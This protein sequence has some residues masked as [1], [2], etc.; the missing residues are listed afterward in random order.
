MPSH[1]TWTDHFPGNFMWSN[2]TLVCKGMAP[3]GAV[4]LGEIELICERLH[5]REGEPAA[6]GEEW[7]ALAARVE[8][9]ADQAAAQG[10][11][12]T[13]GNCYLRAG[14]YY[15]TGERFVP[16]GEKKLEIYRKALRCSQEGLKR[17][18]PNIEFVEVPYEGK[19]LPAYFMKA[20]GANG[21][22][23]KRAP[24]V[25]LFDGMDNCKEM[26]VLFAGIEFAHRGIHTL[27]IDGP[28]QGE[29]LRLRNIYARPDYEVAGTAAYEFV[30][31]RPDVDAKKV[32]I[33]GYSFGGYYAPR[34]AA[35]EQRYAA[36]VALGALHWDLHAWQSKIKEQLKA[37]PKKSAQSNFQFQWIL[38]VNDSEVALER[39]RTFSLEGIANRITCPF[40]V[41]HGEND[42]VVPVAAAHKLHA[43]VGSKN[44]T[45]KIF[46]PEE[47]G[48]EHCQVDNRQLGIDYIADW[49]SA[50][51]GG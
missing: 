18:H 24:T 22:S 38:G 16:L 21:K 4:A 31:A 19:T 50:N 33:M 28:G 41:T 3:Y 25:V 35:L 12:A 11:Q 42:R 17:R 29:S 30:A 36:C 5:A 1:N 2:A 20:S 14:S 44:K 47:T 51:I 40:L 37:D 7:C 43:A 39:A 9:M 8:Q 23:T 10:R 6:W 13:A 45:L 15:Y 26:S 34:I 48:A 49:L 32:A 46:K 27:A